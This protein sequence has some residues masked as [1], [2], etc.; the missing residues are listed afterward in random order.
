MKRRVERV[1]SMAPEMFHEE[2][3]SGPGKPVIVTDALDSWIARS[4]WDFDFFKSQYGTS[5]VVPE[6]FSGT[7]LVKRRMKLRDFIDYLEAPDNPPPGCWIDP[8]TGLPCSA[9]VLPSVRPLYLAW[10]A[11]SQHGELQRQVEL[12]PR[13]VE[14][15]LPF[16]PFFF[17]SRGFP[18]SAKCVKELFFRRTAYRTEKFTYEAPLR[19]ST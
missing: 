9:P 5:S 6:S 19:F 13:F 17:S 7:T 2:Y 8:A 11:F 18:Q 16:L 10:S 1:Q 14:D 4:K 3:L 12:S 15:W